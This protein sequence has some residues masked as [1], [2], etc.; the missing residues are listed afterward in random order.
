MEGEVPS[1]NIDELFQKAANHLKTLVSK[2]DSDK[3]LFFYARFKQAN[4]GPCNTPK[5][6]FFDFQ[7]KQKWEAWKKLGTKSRDEAKREYVDEIT[8]LDPEWIEKISSGEA[9]PK[10]PGWVAVS[11]LQ[12][13][14]EELS[15]D[16][17]S[18]FDWCKEGN[19]ENMIN[20]LATKSSVDVNQKD[21][22]GMGLLHWACDRG[23]SEVVQMLI[24]FDA[25]INIQDN[26]GQTPLHYASSC[27]HA[28]VVQVLLS[29]GADKSIEDFDNELPVDLADD[30]QIKELLRLEND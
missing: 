28:H 4:E 23:Y 8:R 15:N 30:K 16:Q 12:N 5:P 10:Q 19:V 21:D 18:I 29:C 6:G 20:M 1:R 9:P 2:V 25:D 7:G 26:D 13:T 24:K 22:D 14:E 17:K 3:L 11:C 27:S